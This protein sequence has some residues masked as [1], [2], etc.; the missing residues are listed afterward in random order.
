[1]EHFFNRIKELFGS[2]ETDLHQLPVNEMSEKSG[3]SILQSECLEKNGFQT[4]CGTILLFFEKK[5]YQ[6]KE[7]F[8]LLVILNSLSVIPYA[9]AV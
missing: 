8:S 1:M 9:R 3:I 6:I 4:L 7:L 5:V 2:T